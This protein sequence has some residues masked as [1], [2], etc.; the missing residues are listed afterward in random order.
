MINQTEVVELL[1]MDECMALMADTLK[2]LGRG[3]A[4][5]PLRRGM[6]MPE[7]G[8]LL[9]MMP[10]YMGN[11]ESMGLKVL[12]IFPGNEG[13]E[14]DSHLGAVLLFETRHGSLQAIIDASS[15]TA[16]RT[17]AVSGVATELLA[18]PDAATL[19]ILGASTQAY[20]HLE[21]M[22]RAR[23]IT[24]VRVWNRTAKNAE[25]FAHHASDKHGITMEV[26][27]TARAAVT[28]ADIICTTTGAQEPVL[29]G[30]WLAPGA[31]IN[32][33]GSSIPFARELDSAAVVKS[34]LFVDRRESALN[35]AGDLII[36]KKEGVI[37][38]DHILGEIGD[39]LLGKI[40]GRTSPHEIT[41]FKSLGIAVEDIASAHHI[42]K[43]AVEK[44]MGIWVEFGGQRHLF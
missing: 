6:R 44:G 42:Y 28:G 23:K 7:Q 27:D 34:R 43:K 15:I 18:R 25:Q 5:N 29:C 8:A 4:I 41:V 40:E 32:A 22:L 35:E 2:A 3:Q 24:S 16:I 26:T 12:S 33:V 13:T 39:I 9:A 10:G 20:S 14:Y 17:A 36:P 21:A 31:H 37:G 19:A 38:D 30:E 1:P 11:I